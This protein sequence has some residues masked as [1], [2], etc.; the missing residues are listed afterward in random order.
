MPIKPLGLTS[1]YQLGSGK[2]SS[3]NYK[4]QLFHATPW[5]SLPKR[6]VFVSV[7]ARSRVDVS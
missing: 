7:F 6:M 1:R 5:P 4:R 2:R 3:T